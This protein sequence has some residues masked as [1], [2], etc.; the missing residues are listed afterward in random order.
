M[1]WI[2]SLLIM[3]MC[4]INIV[5][6]GMECARQKYNLAFHFT[7]RR[8]VEKL[9]TRFRIDGCTIK[10]GKLVCISVI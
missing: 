2:I 7:G 5:G 1:E 8:C 3:C 9:M 10:R 6:D 4:C